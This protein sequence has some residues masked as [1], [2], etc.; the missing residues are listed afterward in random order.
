MY[1]R[2]RVG[3]GSRS[4]DL[5]REKKTLLVHMMTFSAFLTK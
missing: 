1:T 3:D 4:A 2:H 5:S